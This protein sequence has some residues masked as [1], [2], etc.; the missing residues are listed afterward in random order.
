MVAYCE[1]FIISCSCIYTMVVYC[2]LCFMA[3]HMLISIFRT[4]FGLTHYITCH[5]TP[6]RRGGHWQARAPASQPPPLAGPTQIR[7]PL[8]AAAVLRRR[9]AC[10][11]AAVML[12]LVLAACW[13]QHLF[14]SS[15][16]IQSSYGKTLLFTRQYFILL[17]LSICRNQ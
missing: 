3:Y 6:C 1:L 17:L 12:V 9:K 2:G 10:Q 8:A 7:Q 13:I 14:G 5:I 15:C 4:N 11:C 16:W